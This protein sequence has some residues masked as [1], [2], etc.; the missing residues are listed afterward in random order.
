MD[1]EILIAIL[2]ILSLAFLFLA[3]I[4]FLIFYQIYKIA[5]IMRKSSEMLN[6]WSN[7]PSKLFSRLF[8][9]KPD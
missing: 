7:H 6:Y 2:I 3:T 1:N 8:G 9:K 4:T 5:R